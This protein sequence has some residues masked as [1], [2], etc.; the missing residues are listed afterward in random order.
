MILQHSW[1]AYQLQP[2]WGV[3]RFYIDLIWQHH[4]ELCL[5][6]LK[7]KYLKW[8]FLICMIHIIFVFLM[9]YSSVTQSLA[10]ILIPLAKRCWTT[11]LWP[12]RVA[13]CEGELSSCMGGRIQDLT[14]LCILATAYF[15]ILYSIFVFQ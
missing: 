13:T 3:L 11:S 15:V 5:L 1:S 10:L 6:P 9:N 12:V 14:I 7:E 8:L 4:V 2:V